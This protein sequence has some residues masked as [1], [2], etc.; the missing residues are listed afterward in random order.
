LKRHPTFVKIF[1]K[2]HCEKVALFSQ[3]TDEV[4]ASRSGWELLGLSAF[5]S[6]KHNSSELNPGQL[7]LQKNKKDP[8][9]STV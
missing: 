6:S 2:H 1:V 9:S 3:N 5:N 8:A 4:T 7:Y